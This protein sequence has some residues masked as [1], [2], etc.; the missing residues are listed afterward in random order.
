MA[1]QENRSRFRQLPEVQADAVVIAGGLFGG[2]PG[3]IVVASEKLTRQRVVDTATFPMHVAVASATLGELIQ[4]EQTSDDEAMHKFAVSLA[5]LSEG[6]EFVRDLHVLG[7]TIGIET[8]IESSELVSAAGMHGIRVEA[9]GETGIRFQLPLWIGDDDQ[10]GPAESIRR[11]D[12]ASRKSHCRTECM[13]PDRVAPASAEHH[14]WE[15]RYFAC[16]TF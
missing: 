3:G 10:I 1:A 15:A 13:R 8:D 14:S 11:I 9:A 7:A 5:E 6:F 16:N 2:L 4:R 12:G